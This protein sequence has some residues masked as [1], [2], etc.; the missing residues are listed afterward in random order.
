VIVVPEYRRRSVGRIL[1]QAR[2]DWIAQRDRWAYYFAN[3][4]NRV[5][6]EL[7]QQFGFIELTREFSHPWATFEGG[8]GILFRAELEYGQ[9]KG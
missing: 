6:I 1:T 5:S 9:P 8:I 7:H 2:L 4:Q 3:A